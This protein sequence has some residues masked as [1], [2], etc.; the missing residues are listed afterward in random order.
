MT[1]GSSSRITPL[2]FL[3]LMIFSAGLT[4]ADIV[5]S[6]D[7]ETLTGTAGKDEIIGGRGND[8]L[9]GGADDDVLRGGQGDDVL[10]GGIGVD[11]LYGGLG[12]DRFVFDLNLL[13]IDE[14]MDFNPEQGDTVLLQFGQSNKN[15]ELQFDFKN[16]NN[17]DV[18]VNPD[19]DLEIESEHEIWII[20]VNARRDYFKWAGI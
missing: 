9:N 4:A 10:Y 5:G 8:I 11:R 14:I 17:D 18:R 12:A 3:C 19:G 20:A 6:S 7:D 2:C 1:P 15:D 16:F 13:E